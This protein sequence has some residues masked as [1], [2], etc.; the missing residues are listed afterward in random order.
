MNTK[1]FLILLA[2]SLNVGHSYAQDLN[3]KDKYETIK[4][5]KK[6]YPVEF[7]FSDNYLR[8]TEGTVDLADSVLTDFMASTRQEPFDYLSR[9]IRFKKIYERLRTLHVLGLTMTRDKE[10]KEFINNVLESLVGV[11]DSQEWIT[12]KFKDR[13][14]L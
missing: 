1:L 13:S 12:N 14:Q 5:F 2:I 8:L 4:S 3:Y 7:A 6:K 11:K 9:D 10:R